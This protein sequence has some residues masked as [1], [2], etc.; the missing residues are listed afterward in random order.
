VR[1]IL[2]S[3][4][5]STLVAQAPLEKRFQEDLAFLAGPTLQGRGNGYP[6]L[7][8]AAAFLIK[9]YEGLGLHPTLQRFP[10]VDRIARKSAQAALG[11]GT[12]LQW[13]KDIEAIGFSAD[14]VFSAKPLVFAGYGMKG[15]G[16]DDLEG[17][18]AQGKVILM[19]RRVPDLMVFAASGRMEKS[20]LG[21]VQRL[22]K[23]GAAAVIVLEEEELPRA[24][25]REEGPLKL[26][27]PVLS[28]PFRALSS[29]CGDLKARL[30]RIDE[31][32]KPQ[33]LDFT[34]TKGA[35]LNLDLALE[36]HQAQL[37]NLAA[38]IPGSDPRLKDE[39]IVLGAHLDHLGRGERQSLG[40]ESGRG[41]IHPGAD[42]NAS[43][44]A[45]VLELARELKKRT[46]RRSI[47]LLHVSGE[48]EGLLG[49]A[50]WVQNPT[51]PLPTVKFMLNFDMVGRLDPLKP[52]LQLGGLGAPKAALAQAK[53]LA[54]K[55][56]A[57]GEDL[58]IAVGGSDHMS[59]AAAK[60]PT[61]F[62][63]TGVHTDYHRP[64]DTPEKLNLKGMATVTEM[65]ERIVRELADA[66]QVP[67]FDP[68]TAK[69]PAMRG[70]PVRVAFGSVP[71]FAE[72]PKGFR[73]NGTSPGSAA[74]AIGLKAGDIIVT[75]GGRTIRNLYD[76]QEALSAF[77]PGDKVRVKWLRGEATQEAEATLK[78]R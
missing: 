68:E 54:P 77:K 47:L 5:A 40:G 15:G 71:D 33:S 23:A 30:Q 67:P 2:L 48:E 66:E 69:L 74:E 55:D 19:A 72:N 6:E 16:Y 9:G 60:I 76:F 51:V 56:L 35:S 34:G 37:P 57:V 26:E 24:L 44:T 20:V 8:Q 1:S 18:D 10:F 22:Q 53:S 28:L 38:V 73:I 41:Q 46:T 52:T 50:Y 21:R 27:I 61:F 45:M 17:L 65:A 78:G 43:G 14:G 31:A 32:G 63:F 62:F 75:F 49:S 36:R 12:V 13:G 29:L 42:D 4:L 7:D 25:A 58:G 11:D 3:L 39:F 64:S 59:F 70:G